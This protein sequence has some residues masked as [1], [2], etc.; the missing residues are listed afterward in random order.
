MNHT[1]ANIIEF[2]LGEVQRSQ[3]H[4]S[5]QD[6]CW[7]ETPTYY[8]NCLVRLCT[9]FPDEEKKKLVYFDQHGKNCQ[10]NIRVEGYP[11][12]RLDMNRTGYFPMTVPIIAGSKDDIYKHSTGELC[13]SISCDF[14]LPG[15]NGSGI[16]ISFHATNEIAIG[17][18]NAVEVLERRYHILD[19]EEFK[20]DNLSEIERIY[21][22]GLWD[23][24]TYFLQKYSPWKAT[25]WIRVL[26]NALHSTLKLPNDTLP[27]WNKYPHRKKYL[28]IVGTRTTGLNP[29]IIHPNHHY[30]QMQDQCL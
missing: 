9:S 13:S 10:L 4:V 30:R 22:T 25:H 28:A 29:E 18:C 24:V 5:I 17:Y 6:K 11:S 12:L 3:S 2:S 15:G 7:M 14:P 8:N 16:M 26:T 1:M 20:N 21:L 19:F 27:V 23:D